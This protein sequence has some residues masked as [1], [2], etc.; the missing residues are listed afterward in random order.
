MFFDVSKQ[1]LPH[2]H[3]V[4]AEDPV[5]EGRNGSFCRQQPW[6]VHPFRLRTL[7][8]RETDDLGQRSA[9][10]PKADRPACRVC[11]SLNIATGSAGF[12]QKV[13]TR[14]SPPNLDNPGCNHMQKRTASMLAGGPHCIFW[15]CDPSCSAR[16]RCPARTP[17]RGRGRSG[18]APESQGKDSKE[19]NSWKSQINMEKPPELAQCQYLMLETLRGRY[20]RGCRGTGPASRK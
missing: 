20:G 14:S 5:P 8:S 16:E 15:L 9:Q 6:A 10:L 19:M 18:P 11:F 7:C 1:F 4:A 13:S 12:A 3:T 2:T 17:H